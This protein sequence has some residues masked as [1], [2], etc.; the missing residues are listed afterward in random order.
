MA[1]SSPLPPMS[2]TQ[3]PND[4]PDA[5]SGHAHDLRHLRHSLAQRFSLLADKADDPVIER[6]I[7][8]GVEL[9]GATPWIL[10]AAI[11]IAS[12][13]LNVNSTAVIIGAMLISPLMGPIMGVGLGVAVYDFPLI[14]KSFWN[15]AIASGISLAVST[16]YFAITPLAE[17]QSELLAR[18]SPTLWDVLIA[19][20]GGFAG[21]IG[22]TREEKSNVIPGVAIATALMPPLCTAGYGLATGQWGYFGGALY[23][24][25]INC[26]FIALATILGLRLVRVPVHAFVDARTERRMRTW[27]LVVAL[28]TALPS[29]WL[30]YRLVQDEVFNSRARAFVRDEF[31]FDSAHVADTRVDPKTGLI[32]VLATG[33]DTAPW[34]ALPVADV[35]DR[36][37]PND[38]A[39][40]PI[41]PRLRSPPPAAFAGAGQPAG[42]Q[43]RRP[44]HRAPHPRGHV[45]LH[46]ATPWILMAA[47]SSPDRPERQFHRG[48]HR[49]DA[50][51]AADGA[52]HGRRPGRGGLR[53][54]ADPQV[55]L[56]SRHR[57]GHQPGRLH[58]VLRDHPAGGGAVGAAGAHLPTLWDVLI[59]VFGGFAGVIGATREES[60]TSSRA[61]RSPPR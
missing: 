2:M 34:P 52:D 45:E 49:R 20:F 43:G 28:A 53:L 55:V 58:P 42:G 25:S 6:R 41:R 12:I 44:G 7:R 17:A 50:D 51:L 19:V 3:T 48:D 36:E 56:E 37:S 57:L 60:R 10:M 61:W 5:P 24:Y 39:G 59:A 4:A 29:T 40:R 22:A 46:G 31:R 54:P 47:T 13:G 18:T 11:F 14:R 16:L 8:E 23:L 35:D 38:A 30:A 21:V 26:V 1:G 32:E 15:L 9:H 33:V 27:L